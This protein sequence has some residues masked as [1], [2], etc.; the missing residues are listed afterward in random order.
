M[1]DIRFYNLCM[2]KRFIVLFFLVGIA[3]AQT[4]GK[5]VH[6]KVD[7]IS[8]N[9]SQQSGKPFYVALY[10]RMDPGWHI[11]WNNPG[12]SG[13]G[14]SVAWKGTPGFTPGPLEWPTPQRMQDGPLVEYGYTSEV[15][16][17]AKFKAPDNLAA[18]GEALVIADL[19]WLECEKVCVPQKS[20]L[21]VQ[22]PIAASEP[23]ANPQFKDLFTRTRAAIPVDMP[24]D[25]RAFAETR[26][27]TFHLTVNIPTS[28]RPKATDKVVYFPLVVSLIENAAPQKVTITATGIKIEL[29]K[30]EQYLKP[31]PVLPGVLVINKKAFTMYPSL[32]EI[33]TVK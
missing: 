16:L 17:P 3:V 15:L 14:P 29:G 6:T 8:E 1:T 20:S 32:S 11:Y 13:Q 23:K 33:K 19:K 27:N 5:P 12:D 26:K 10:F 28:D 24:A 21:H 2:L 9:L 22:I 30:S 31:V 7:L 25:W 4:S 18:G